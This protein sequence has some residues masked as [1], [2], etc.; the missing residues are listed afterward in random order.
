MTTIK[1]MDKVTILSAIIGIIV[2]ESIA[3]SQGING[4]GLSLAIAAIAGLG[5]YELDKVIKIIKG[6]KGKWV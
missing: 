4:T 2:I 6:V 1:I 5:G 3:L